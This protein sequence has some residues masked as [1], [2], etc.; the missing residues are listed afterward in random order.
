MTLSPRVSHLYVGEAH[1]ARRLRPARGTVISVR[2]RPP[3]R[4]LPGGLLRYFDADRSADARRAG[5]DHRARVRDSLHATRGLDAHLAPHRAAH[6]RHVRHGRAR[7]GEPR[8][9]LH[10]VRARALRR[11]TRAHLLL[12]GQQGRLDDRLDEHALLVRRLDDRA[13]VVLDGAVVAAL[14]SADVDDHVNLARAVENCT[15]GLVSLHVRQSRAQRKADDRAHGH[16]RPAQDTRRLLHPS[17]V[18]AHARELVLR[19][20][21]AQTPYVRLARLWLQ[22]RV[23]NQTRPIAR[24]RRLAQHDPYARRTRVHNPLHPLRAAIKTGAPAPA[25]PVVLVPLA[26]QTRDDDIRY[27]FHKALEIAVV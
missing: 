20:L 13:Y 6:Q 22:Q 14:Q 10:E 11:Q 5:L 27:L 7:L 1:S 12:V 21:L 19:C 15:P 18:H 2:R 4:P 9:G 8:R 17:R 26:V 16:A 3:G 25:R 24:R 23:I